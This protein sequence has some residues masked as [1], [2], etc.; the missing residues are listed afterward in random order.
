MRELITLAIATIMAL[1][2]SGSGDKNNE[3]GKGEKKSQSAIYVDTLQ[4]TKQVFNRQIVCNGKLRAAQKSDIVYAQSGIIEQ[5]NITNGDVVSKGDLLAIINREDAEIELYKCQ[6]EMEKAR[7]DLLD[8]LVGQGYNSADSLN[9]PQAVMDHARHTSGYN[10]ANDAVM[11][12]ERNLNDCYIKAPFA[13]RI[14]N[15]DAKI[16]DRSG[17]LLC[18][19]IDDSYFDVVFHLLEA[20]LE[21]VAKGQKVSVTPFID[22]THQFDGCITQINPLIDDSGQ[23][24]VYAQVHNKSGYLIEGMNVKL[25]LNREV[26][27]QYVVPKEAVVLRDGYH[28]VFCYVDGE[29]VWTYVDVV[30][31]NIDSH[32]ITGNEEKQTELSDGDIIIISGNS[33]L[34]DGVK[35]NIKE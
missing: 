7:I 11:Q 23:I 10:S 8:R 14:A 30:M 15:L 25:T 16:Y 34:A 21:E 13:G 4:L 32:L 22:E 27:N 5:I 17:D 28:V 1:S 3:S 9:I 24:K 31:S 6:R 18:T 12:A 35:V 29:T 19:L 20:E 26:K 33:N 2:C